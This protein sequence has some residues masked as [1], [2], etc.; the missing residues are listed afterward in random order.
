MSLKVAVKTKE[1]KKIVYIKLFKYSKRTRMQR[2]VN[3]LTIKAKLREIENFFIETITDLETLLN[4][5][6]KKEF[7]GIEVIDYLKKPKEEIEAELYK[8]KQ[9]YEFFQKKLKNDI[10][11]WNYFEDVYYISDEEQK[12][13]NDAMKKD[14]EGYDLREYPKKKIFKH[15][16]KLNYFK[17]EIEHLKDTQKNV[18][19]NRIVEPIKKVLITLKY[20]G[21]Y[22]EATEP[23]VKLLARMEGNHSDK[24]SAKQ[25]ELY[26]S[27]YTKEAKINKPLSNKDRFV[28]L[29]KDYKNEISKLKSTIIKRK[30]K[31]LDKVIASIMPESLK[32]FEETRTRTSK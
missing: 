17:N 24:L 18:K 5:S 4:D 9:E 25:R 21:D 16:N 10:Y 32:L 20:I 2:R 27:Y 6:K 14:Y 28:Q 29:K 22:D 12:S 1:D 23:L 19:R 13:F 3:Y 8:Q 31:N 30:R 11:G 7:I 26:I 15:I